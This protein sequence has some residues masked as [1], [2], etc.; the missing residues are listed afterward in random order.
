MCSRQP[1]LDTQ[2]RELALRQWFA[3]EQGQFL[4][5]AER[6]LLKEVVAGLS[7]YHLMELGAAGQEQLHDSFGHSHCFSFGS[8]LSYPSAAVADYE[9]IPLPS[10]IIDTGIL[11]H[12]LEFSDNPHRILNEASRVIIPGGHLVLVMFNPVSLLG[13]VKWPMGLFSHAPLWHYR[14]LRSGRVLDWLKLL[15]FQP[16]TTRMDCAFFPLRCDK[17]VA[18]QPPKLK[19]LGEM[20]ILIGAVTVIVARKTLLRPI[21]GNGFPYRAKRAVGLKFR[22]GKINHPCNRLFRGSLDKGYYEKS[23]NFY[24]RGLSR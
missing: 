23:R 9:S 16:V 21:H 20:G 19:R 15:H 10:E 5:A 7:G 2:A 4:L 18:A 3:S 17:G 22:A 11:H 24:R 8:S 13:L 12:V 14:S 1:K 6:V